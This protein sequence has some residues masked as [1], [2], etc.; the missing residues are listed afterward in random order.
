MV[1]LYLNPTFIPTTKVLSRF[2]Q[3]FKHRTWQKMKR[4]KNV[5]WESLSSK[6]EDLSSMKYKKQ[7]PRFDVEI[8][9][10]YTVVKRVRW[11]GKRML[12][13]VLTENTIRVPLLQTQF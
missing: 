6:V 7:K 8:A 10:A 12:V 2:I 4:A 9:P 11:L 1:L 3:R 5:E 13:Q